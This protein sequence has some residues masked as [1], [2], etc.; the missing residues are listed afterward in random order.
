[1]GMVEYEIILGKS[2]RRS[3]NGTDIPKTVATKKEA[4]DIAKAIAI[5]NL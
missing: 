1:M 3:A 5:F 2:F 4:L